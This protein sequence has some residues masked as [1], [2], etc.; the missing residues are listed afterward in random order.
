[1][2][3]D[4]YRVRAVVDTATGYIDK[5]SRFIYQ[6]PLVMEYL[7][8]KISGWNLGDFMYDIGAKNIA[9]YALT[10][11]TEI[12]ITDIKRSTKHIQIR[13]IGDKKIQSAGSMVDDIEVISKEMLVK[14]YL[15][16]TLDKILICSV[17]HA[18]EIF[19]E[20]MEEGIELDDLISITAAVCSPN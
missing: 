1:M 20:L 10:E 15:N 3:K 12:A 11:F 18:N 17:F 14:E 9:L 8:R 6:Y 5:T 2:N 16:G 19:N 7:N 4:N 13:C